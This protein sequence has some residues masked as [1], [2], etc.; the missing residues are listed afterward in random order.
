LEDVIL[1]A[2]SY[3]TKQDLVYKNLNIIKNKVIERYTGV[4]T[5]YFRIYSFSN[6]YIVIINRYEDLHL[7]MITKDLVIKLEIPDEKIYKDSLLFNCVEVKDN[8]IM[9]EFTDSNIADFD[10][11]YP[12]VCAYLVYDFNGN[13]IEVSVYESKNE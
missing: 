3:L 13:L 12:Y 4:E 1:N 7:F 9:M 2:F 6:F 8:K 10:F 11:M 5:K